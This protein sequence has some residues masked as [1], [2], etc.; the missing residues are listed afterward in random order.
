[1]P[2][3][4]TENFKEILRNDG[5][6]YALVS[7]V[8]EPTDVNFPNLPDWHKEAFED[9][10]DESFPDAKVICFEY[11]GSN[12]KLQINMG[13]ADSNDGCFGALFDSTGNQIVDILSTG[14]N[15][16]TFQSLKS[17]DAKISNEHLAKITPYLRYNLLLNS[18]EL[19]YLVF[20]ILAE[21]DCL[22][23]LGYFNDEEEDEEEE[24]AEN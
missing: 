5:Y 10:P 20:K 6:S 13:E 2:K 15:E 1:M 17:D 12:Y 9:L 22:V 4:S 24:N 3:V 8:S 21:N 23:G 19:E 11:N 16:T 7:K 18:T 14:D